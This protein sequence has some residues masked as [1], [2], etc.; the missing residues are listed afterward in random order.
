MKQTDQTLLEQMQITEF[1]IEFRK[2]LFSLN[3][4]DVKALLSC[5]STIE[6]KIDALVDEF[7]RLQTSVP[8]IALLIGDADTLR[9]LRTAQRRYILDLFSGVYDL[10]YVNNR[11]RIGLVHKRIGVEPRLYLSAVHTLKGLLH[12]AIASASPVEQ[13]RQ[14]VRDALDKLLSFDVTLVF[15]TYIRSLLSEIANAK[16]K[17][18]QYARTLEQKVKERTQQL[19]DQSRTDPLTGLL[20]VRYLQESVTKLLRAAQRRAEPVSAVYLDVNDL[21]KINDTQGH[22][23]GDEILRS[24]ANALR[25]TVRPEDSCFRYGGDEFCIILANCRKEQAREEFV[26]RLKDQIR[27]SPNNVSLS[28]GV[29]QTG[30]DEYVD[31][32]ALIRQADEQMYAEKR[33]SKTKRPTVERLFRRSI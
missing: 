33:A 23:K 27:R 30:P 21:K 9:R 22:Q 5:K 26:T 2:E 31:A 15:D 20:N 6:K 7:Y 1:D 24:V 14:A 12:E 28:A 18:E 4:K 19:E 32:N 17:A 25:N 8:E 13:E 11:L 10:D 3:Q 16:D 29:A